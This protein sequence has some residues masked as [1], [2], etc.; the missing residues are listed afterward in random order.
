MPDVQC[1]R[2]GTRWP[3]DRHRTGQD[4]RD[5]RCPSCGHL[6]TPRDQAGPPPLEGRGAADAG[7]Q[8]RKKGGAIYPFKDP[9]TVQR[10]IV[11]RKALADDEIAQRPFESWRRLGDLPEYR[12]F[13]L[14]VEQAAR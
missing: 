13:F 4:G 11:E 8:L 2:C 12:S 1:E 6:F 10:W 14:V 7:W 9:A 3:S 5:A